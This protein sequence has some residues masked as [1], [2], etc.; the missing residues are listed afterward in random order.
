MSALWRDGAAQCAGAGLNAL[1]ADAKWLVVRML[2]V[3]RFSNGF[4]DGACQV[5]DDQDPDE[6]DHD[7]NENR[8]DCHDGHRVN[9]QNTVDGMIVNGKGNPPP[10]EAGIRDRCQ[11]PGTQQEP[12][13]CALILVIICGKQTDDTDQIHA[14]KSTGQNG[15]PRG[16]TDPYLT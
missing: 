2:C 3:R 13:F 14:A 6:H 5:A 10:V 15:R 11:H 8:N 12:V 16:G 9:D 4:S 7:G 1:R